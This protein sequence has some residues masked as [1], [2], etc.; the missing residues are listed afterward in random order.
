MCAALI[1]LRHFGDQRQPAYNQ[2]HAACDTMKMK[3][4]GAGEPAVRQQRPYRFS[5]WADR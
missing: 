1:L 5:F 4:Q 2:D 3:K